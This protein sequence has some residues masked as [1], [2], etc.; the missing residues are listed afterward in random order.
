MDSAS[1]A[2]RTNDKIGYYREHNLP[3]YRFSKLR[4]D[5]LVKTISYLKNYGEVY[6]VRLPVHPLMMNIENELLPD[7]DNKIK[8]ILKKENI[9][10]F[11]MTYL[12]EKCSYTDGNHLYKESGKRITY[13]LA[14]WI[15]NQ[16]NKKD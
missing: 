11:D 2:K 14:K 5:Y 15:F 8:E 7:F 10:Y 3:N 6:L 4:Y 16:K 1:V 12:N 13:I 9:H